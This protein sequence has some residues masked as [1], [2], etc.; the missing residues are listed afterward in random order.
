MATNC[1]IRVILD[2]KDR[3]R[4]MKFVPN[5]KQ[6]EDLLKEPWGDENKEGC[7]DTVNAGG[8]EALIIYHHFDGFVNGVG[9]TLYREYNSYQEALN[10][11]LGGDVSTIIGSYTPYAIREGKDWESICPVAVDESYSSNN[12]EYEYMFKNGKWFVQ[13]F[14]K[15]NKWEPLVKFIKKK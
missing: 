4:D 10:L 7:W 12:E 14:H 1:R 15:S 13:I 8:K 3:N 9:E 6:S 5:E 11:V 2:E